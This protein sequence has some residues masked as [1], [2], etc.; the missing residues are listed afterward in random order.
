MVTVTID[1][2]SPWAR[3][4]D[5]TARSALAEREPSM[6]TGMQRSA[7]PAASIMRVFGSLRA[8]LTVCLANEGAETGRSGV[9]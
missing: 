5:S 2:L 4:G 3:L 9:C 8:F 7:T 1:A 6:S